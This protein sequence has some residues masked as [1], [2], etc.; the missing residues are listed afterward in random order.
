MLN[1]LPNFSAKL[2]KQSADFIRM[3]KAKIN[4]INQT[5]AITREAMK[6]I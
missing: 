3:I 4:M 5:E 6:Y 2:T 1:L